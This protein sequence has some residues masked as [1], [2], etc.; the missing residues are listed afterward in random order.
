[1]LKLLTTSNYIY[2]V[3]YD[4]TKTEHKIF[5]LL[6]DNDDYESEITKLKKS[7]KRDAKNNAANKENEDVN[8][9][10]DLSKYTKIDSNLKELFQSSDV[11]QFKFD[12]I[13]ESVPM[14]SNLTEH[15]K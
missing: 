3:R 1:M 15:L 10:V 5:E 11:F 6:S 13:A 4:P 7:Q 12:N 2:Q 9:N 8:K 14:N